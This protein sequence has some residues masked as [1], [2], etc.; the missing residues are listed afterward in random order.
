M[1]DVAEVKAPV[2]EGAFIESLKRNN[3]KIRED[4][5]ESI[6]E[7]AQITY[8]REIQDM[9]M[10]YKKLDRKRKNMLDLSPTN[11][12]SLMV[13][14]EFD[15]KRFVRDDIEIGVEQRNLQIK[16]EIGYARYKKLFGED[17]PSKIEFT[18]K[19]TN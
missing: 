19:I 2:V 16:L 6:G 9:E 4:R 1:S 18:D 17:F 12:D 7:D 10:S 15:S 3:T 5:A 11:A 14:E 13:A 8:E